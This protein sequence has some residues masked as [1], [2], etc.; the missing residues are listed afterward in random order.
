MKHHELRPDE[1]R[2][3][4]KQVEKRRDEIRRIRPRQQ[5][6]SAEEEGKVEGEGGRRKTDFLLFLFLSFFRFAKVI[7]RDSVDPTWKSGEFN[8]FH[9]M[10][11]LVRDGQAAR[12]LPL[13]R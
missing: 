8:G 1:L 3:E 10:G 2:I 6:L 5:V 7:S 4:M 11:G 9:P 13:C 12:Y